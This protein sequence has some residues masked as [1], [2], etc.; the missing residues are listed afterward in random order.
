M[1]ESITLKFDVTP[2]EQED[3]IS[4]TLDYNLD[5]IDPLLVVEALRDLADSEE[6]SYLMWIA[7]QEGYLPGSEVEQSERNRQVRN[8]RN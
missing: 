6:R 7:R 5:T 1:T 2:G 3:L 8:N 4:V